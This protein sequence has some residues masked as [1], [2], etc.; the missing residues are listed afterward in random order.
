MISRTTRIK[1][2]KLLLKKYKSCVTI[3]SLSLPDASASGALSKL[4]RSPRT[5]GGNGSGGGRRRRGGNPRQQRQP[6]H[7]QH[8]VVGGPSAGGAKKNHQ[9]KPRM[10]AIAQVDEFEAGSV[11][12]PGSKKQ[13]LNHLLNFK[14]ETRGHENRNYRGDRHKSKRDFGLPRPKY[15][16]EQYLQAK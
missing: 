11:F 10:P 13:N 16:K 2:T 5:S 9:P 3:S 1:V 6:S 14:Y 8:G 12:H 15:I 7:E 4:G